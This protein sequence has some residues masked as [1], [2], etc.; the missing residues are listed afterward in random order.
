MSLKGLEVHTY[1][2]YARQYL[3]RGGPVELALRDLQLNDLCIAVDNTS[4]GYLLHL[5]IVSLATI[6]FGTQHKSTSITTHGYFLH[7]M[8]LKQLNNALS[9]PQCQFRDDVL[10]SVMVLVL[11]EAFV[12][13]GK[14]NYLKHAAGLE[15]LLELRGPTMVSSPGS[16]LIFKAVRKIIILASMRRRQATI[17]ARKEWKDISWQDESVE[18][19]AEKYLFDVLAD[20]T[21]LVAEHD[22]LKRTGELDL[23]GIPHRR[24]ELARKT[25]SI[26]QQLVI[27]KAGWDAHLET[28]AARVG[29]QSMPGKDEMNDLPFSTLLIF[30]SPSAATIVMLYNT[31]L[32]YILRILAPLSPEPPSISS[33]YSVESWDD[34]NPLLLGTRAKYTAMERSAAIDICRCIPYYQSH[35]SQ[36]DSGSL[37]I[38]HLAVRAAFMTFGRSSSSGGEWMVHLLNMGNGEVF[39]KGLW[40]D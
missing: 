19:Q 22:Q 8:A 14:N 33:E 20:Y 36:L 5:T 29:V 30:Q 27:W 16:F 24:G 6:F 26:L 12:P 23:E 7:G 28:S 3:L 18:S 35:K 34:T 15:K 38:A 4:G 17:L 2:C 39:A 37:T 1:I 25:G 11:L 13:T 32:I 31:S 9:D 40:V 21:I 10:H